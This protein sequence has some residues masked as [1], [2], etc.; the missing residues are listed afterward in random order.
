[1]AVDA[2]TAASAARLR[3]AAGIALGDALHLATAARA[4]AI[5]FLTNDRRLV[6]RD[7][8]L[9]VLILDDLI[10]SDERPAGDHEDRGLTGGR[11][12]SG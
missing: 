3:G 9:D 10:A 4:G 1:M 6:G 11:P 8:K 5:A 12:S 2:D 7:T